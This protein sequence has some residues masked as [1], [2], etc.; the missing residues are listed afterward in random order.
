MARGRGLGIE[1]GERVWLELVA[2]EDRTRGLLVWLC[3]HLD[4]FQT[5]LTRS[6]EVEHQSLLVK[7]VFIL[8]LD[9]KLL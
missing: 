8:K 5:R 4:D 2:P 1:S 6:V 7:G 9:Q 3:S